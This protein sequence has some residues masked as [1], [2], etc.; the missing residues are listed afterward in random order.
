M[1]SSP[2]KP[3]SKRFLPKRSLRFTHQLKFSVS[4]V[5]ERLRNSTSPLP[6]SA[7]SVRYRKMVAQA[8]TGGLTSLKFHSYA[9]I[10]PVGCRKNSCSIRSSCSF[11]KSVS[12]VETARVW[13]A[14][15]QSAY[16]LYSHL[17]G[18]EIM[19]LFTIWN[20]S[21]FRMKCAPGFIGSSPCSVSHRSTSKKK[22]CLDQSI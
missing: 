4:L 13:K 1:L 6:S 20:H 18:I 11:A 21:L 22:Y 12:T 9:G 17:S 3:P 16:H 5:K 15:S 7:C 10:C 2:R 19:C 8:C 14:N